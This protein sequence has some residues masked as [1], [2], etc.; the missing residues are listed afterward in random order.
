M[1]RETN[2]VL[3]GEAIARITRPFPDVIIRVQKN[4][5]EKISIEFAI[6]DP[7]IRRSF[8]GELQ[9]IQ[10]GDPYELF[11]ESPDNVNGEDYLFW[12]LVKM[13]EKVTVTNVTLHLIIPAKEEFFE[14]AIVP[15]RTT[16]Q[17]E[18]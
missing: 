5:D 4:G 16:S 2:E 1:L 11:T 14:R 9:Q 3:N 12:R 17:L 10:E 15:T 18:N 7:N 8:L 13:G 6:A